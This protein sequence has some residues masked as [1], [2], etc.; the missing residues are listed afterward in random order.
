[1]ILGIDTSSARTSTA[2][3]DADRVVAYAEHDDPRRHGEVLAG[4]VQQ[5]LA[6]AGHPS[7]DRIACGVGPGPYTG[8]RVGIATAVALGLAWQVPVHGAC[9]L[10]ARAASLASTART[11]FVL[12][13]DARRGEVY[14]AQYTADGTRL[15]GPFVCRAR[16]ID[17]DIRDWPWSGE[18]AALAGEAV[19]F[20]G[21][22][23]RPTAVDVARLVQRLVSQGEPV[24]PVVESLAAHGTDDGSTAARLAGHRLLPPVPLYVRRPDAMGG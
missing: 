12:A 16:D 1:M 14:W 23:T 13:S 7:I 21:D 24:G 6:D 9:S 10:D 15:D 4:L 8:L 2:V 18:G 19:A 5:V 20:T 22:A 17:P 11:A 3:L